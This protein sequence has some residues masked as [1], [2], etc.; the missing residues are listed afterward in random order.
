[1]MTKIKNQIKIETETNRNINDFLKQEAQIWHA[2]LKKNSLKH[3]GVQGREVKTNSKV[4]NC[5]SAI[6]SLFW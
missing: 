5:K 2:N 3:Q 6:A 1:M 4:L